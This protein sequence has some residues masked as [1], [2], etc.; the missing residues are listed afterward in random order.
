MLI[1][2]PI[3]VFTAIALQRSGHHVALHMDGMED[4]RSKWG[5][6]LRLMHRTARKIAV[7]SDLLLVTDSKA[8]QEWYLA[9]HNR[10][11][12][13][14]TY[15]GCVAAETD[16]TH[17]W[18]QTESSDFFM[19]VARP[20]PEN[21]IL[22]MCQ[23][24]IASGSTHRLVIVGAPIGKSKYW[25]SVMELVS[26]HSNIELA[27]SIWDRQQLCDL[28]RSTLGVIHGHTVGGTNPALVDALSHGSPVM[29]HDNAYNREVL[30][31]NG[32]LWNSVDALTEMLRS[33]EPRQFSIDV[34]MFLNRYNWKKVAH[35]YQELLNLRP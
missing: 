3:N 8:I 17:R 2:N 18:V 19:V 7:R 12:E 9:T 28:Y 31:A 33:Y 24:F 25:T 14:I 21:Q 15:G 29:A 35:A 20:E 16:N 27:G 23:A 34:D 11:T 4:Q 32:S 6:F 10:T 13:M 26:N 30:Q 1:V 22:E 5:R